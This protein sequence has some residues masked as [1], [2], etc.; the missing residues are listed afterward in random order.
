MVRCRVRSAIDTI[1][2]VCTNGGDG[3][4]AAGGV[5]FLP[6]GLFD[7]PRVGVGILESV[8]V[9]RQIVLD[10]IGFSEFSAQFDGRDPERPP[11]GLGGLMVELADL[12]E[13]HEGR[14]H[15]HHLKRRGR[16]DHRLDRRPGVDPEFVG[17]PQRVDPLERAVG[18]RLPFVRPLMIRKGQRHREHVAGGVEVKVFCR[19]LRRLGQDLK[20]DPMI[21]QDSHH[22]PRQEQFILD[23]RVGVRQKR[24]QHPPFVTGQFSRLLFERL[25]HA[26]PGPDLSRLDAE[27]LGQRRR[28]AI[29]APML[30]SDVLIDRQRRILRRP[31]LR[32]IDRRHGSPFHVEDSPHWP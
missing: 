3:A 31:A 17:H 12:K 27:P 19:P 10:E 6:A 24:Q 13:I 2:R 8:Q 29:P 28:V 1:D 14:R 5:R 26:R 20:P 30:A 32:F 4:G 16:V 21:R 15:L 11:V 18:H 22:L 23:R 25:D 7:E 9:L